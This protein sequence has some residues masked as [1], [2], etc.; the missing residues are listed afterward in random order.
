[1]SH[2]ERGPGEDGS[3]EQVDV[4]P[5]GVAELPDVRLDRNDAAAR[6]LRERA[7]RSQRLGEQVVILY[8][9][10]ESLDKD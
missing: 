4:Q 8:R 1:M 6:L 5:M 3:V 10:F 7:G 2:R 9:N